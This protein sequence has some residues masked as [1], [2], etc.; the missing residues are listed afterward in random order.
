LGFGGEKNV[1]EI[2]PAGE[3]L[4]HQ[5]KAL[6]KKVVRLLEALR[7]FQ[8]IGVLHHGVLNALDV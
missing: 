7:D 8:G 4:P 3:G 1:T 6:A 2:Q 5:V